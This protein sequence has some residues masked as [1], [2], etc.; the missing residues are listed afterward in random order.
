MTATHLCP[1]ETTVPGPRSISLTISGQLCPSCKE[2]EIF[3]Y[4]QVIQL[5][6]QGFKGA[7]ERRKPPESEA[8]GRALLT[9]AA[10][11]HSTSAFGAGSR[12]LVP[13]RGD[14]GGQ[15]KLARAAAALQER[16]PELRLVNMNVS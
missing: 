2:S 14:A 16:S 3:I 15:E 13:T 5:A 12:T 10:A 6:C 1:R 9:A 11:A 8:K 7:G 4:L